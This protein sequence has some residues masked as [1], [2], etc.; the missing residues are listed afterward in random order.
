MNTG[1]WGPYDIS[2]LG[3]DFGWG[4]L[5]KAGFDDENHQNKDEKSDGQSQIDR[6]IPE[7]S[8]EEGEQG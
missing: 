7:Y 3:I 4:L 5:A 2:Q 6:A 8:G 1:T